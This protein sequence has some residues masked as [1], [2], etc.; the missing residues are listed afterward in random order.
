TRHLTLS[1]EQNVFSLGFSAVSYRSP[2]TNRY[3]YK[4][5]GL[6]PQ[7]TE[8]G[9]DRRRAVYTT[10]P[11]G[12]YV[13]RAQAAS[14]RGSW[15][16]PGASLLIDILPPWWQT[17]WF[18]T[19]CLILVVVL[20]GLLYEWRLRVVANRLT[21]RMEERVA[22]RTRIAQDLHDTVLQGLLSVSLQL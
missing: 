15:G 6:D 13:F 22:E 7:W 16:T 10:L 17:W 1:H 14:L 20:L 9:S 5:E 11:A 4:L 2:A 8:V 18:R 19:A 12:R 3:R 21:L